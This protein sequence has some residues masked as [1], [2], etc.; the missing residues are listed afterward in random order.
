[1]TDF[2]KRLRLT[3][4]LKIFVLKLLWD[5]G[6]IILAQA[7]DEELSDDDVHN[8]A[9]FVLN[10]PVHGQADIFAVLIADNGNRIVIEIGSL[11]A[12]ADSPLE[13][14]Q[15]TADLCHDSRFSG[16]HK[17]HINFSIH[18]DFSFLGKCKKPVRFISHTGLRR[19]YRDLRGTHS[20]CR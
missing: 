15:I 8:F 16:L 10:C 13:R 18:A 19:T 9:V 20:N 7:A 1:M 17:H 2:Q 4:L 11:N 3:E 14:I 12:A 6:K 5:R